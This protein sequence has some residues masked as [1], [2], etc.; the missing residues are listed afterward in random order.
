MYSETIAR[1]QAVVVQGVA[2]RHGKQPTADAQIPTKQRKYGAEEKAAAVRLVREGIPAR[3]VAAQLE[4]DV[5]TVYRWYVAGISA[6]EIDALCASKKKELE[7]LYLLMAEE[8]ASCALAMA[9]SGDGKSAQGA[10]TGSGIFVDKS[11]VLAGRAPVGRFGAN[12]PR[13]VIEQ[14]TQAPTET[15]ENVMQRLQELRHG[16]EEA[17]GGT[18][19]PGK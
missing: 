2:M 6:S 15:P 3:E 5:S 4:C 12:Q 13:Q 18:N 16:T 7:A 19:E 10:A 8:M 11:E 9:Q 1:G 14:P 17:P